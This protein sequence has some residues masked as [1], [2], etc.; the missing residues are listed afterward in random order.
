MLG[1]RVSLHPCW[2]G[3]WWGGGIEVNVVIC[4]CVFMCFHPLN[5]LL[6]P[7]YVC[8]FFLL[9]YYCSTEYSGMFPLIIWLALILL[10]GMLRG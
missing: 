9:L 10:A 2:G 1:H 7:Q 4:F 3:A 8:F 5:V 6:W